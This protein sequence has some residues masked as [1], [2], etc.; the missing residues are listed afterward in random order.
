MKAKLWNGMNSKI[1]SGRKIA[2]NSIMIPY[3]PIKREKEVA[4]YGII[5]ED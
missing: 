5:S 1:K 3:M 2:L 4:E